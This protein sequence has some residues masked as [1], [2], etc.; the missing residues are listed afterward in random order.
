MRWLSPPKVYVLR[1]SFAARTFLLRCQTVYGG[2]CIGKGQTVG[3]DA[4]KRGKRVW[5]YTMTGIAQA[6]GV[7]VRTLKS[8]RASGLM[9]P[10]DLAS[11]MAYGGAAILKRQ[12]HGARE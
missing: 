2:I 10:D 9:N 8:H 1:L 11:V 7:S 6:A 4:G 12:A 5:K 3:L